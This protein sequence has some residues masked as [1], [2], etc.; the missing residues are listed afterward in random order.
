MTAENEGQ[1]G[2][3]LQIPSEIP[4]DFAQAVATFLILGMAGQE[5]WDRIFLES[6]EKSLG[7]IEGILRSNLTFGLHHSDI[8][9]WELQVR[10]H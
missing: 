10:G 7:W 3:L 4:E 6:P 8:K 5:M 1:D 9:W 2:R